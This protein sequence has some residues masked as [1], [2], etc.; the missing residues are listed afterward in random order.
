MQFLDKEGHPLRL[1][2][3][4]SQVNL[5]GS[6]AAAGEAEKKGAPLQFQDI[7]GKPLTL[8]TPLIHVKGLNR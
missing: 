3:K 5:Q 7:H 4:L 6:F 2:T 8:H 1:D